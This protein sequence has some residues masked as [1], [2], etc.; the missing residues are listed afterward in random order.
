M[1][2]APPPTASPTHL[3]R[4]APADESPRTG[5]TFLAAGAML[6][7]MAAWFRYGFD[8]PP[9]AAA[10]LVALAA[11]ASFG[12]GALR[13][14]GQGSTTS[15]AAFAAGGAV[16]L[17]GIAGWLGATFGLEALGEAGG[18][19]IFAV[20]A[21][22]AALG[23]S[24]GS[25]RERLPSSVITRIAL[26]ALGFLVLAAAIYLR[27][28]RK[29]GNDY[30]P[31]QA[32]LFLLGFVL[33]FGAVWLYATTNRTPEFV[34]TFFL[35]LG[36]ALGS[37]LTLYALSRAIVDWSLPSTEPWQTWIV[38]Y[39]LVA[40]L[41]LIY[42]SLTLV[43]NRVEKS[44]VAR[45]SIGGF[46][47]LLYGILALAIFVVFNV[48]VF[49][50]V[51]YTLEW[52]KTRGLT[53]LTPATENLLAGLDKKVEAYVLM[54]PLHGLHL[55][56]K[57]ML[58]N[59]AA[60]APSKFQVFYINPDSANPAER[61]K[62][63]QLANRFKEIVSSG[64]RDDQEMSRGVLLVYGELPKDPNV[65]VPH[66]VIPVRRLFENQMKTFIFKGESEVMKEVDFLARKREK[67]RI[68]LLQG[69]NELDMNDKEG[70]DL[71]SPTLNLSR[72]GAG[73]LVA[74]L[75]KDNYDVRGLS[76][77]PADPEAKDTNI[78]HVAETG[79]GKKAEVPDDCQTLVILSPSAKLSA[80]ALD[81]IERY[82]DR[83]GSLFVGIG[84][85]GEPNF[86]KLKETGLE[87]LL[88]KYGVDVTD[89]FVLHIPTEE[90]RSA[91]RCF[92][93]VPDKGQT[94]LAQQF[95]GKVFRMVTPRIIKAGDVGEVQGRAA[96]G[97]RSEL[98]DLGGGL[99]RLFPD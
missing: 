16:V 53:T 65:P 64:G 72:L 38:G 15:S 3:P 52:S 74:N 54:S 11:L 6:T 83:G 28:V 63:D 18:L 50:T 92:A 96:A 73:K 17:L 75:T 45:Q 5:P 32:A 33:L 14:V 93:E 91:F 37:L 71:T 13:V 23:W 7:I 55:Q 59:A 39:A 81:A 36:S 61:E 29:I 90:F 77:R 40:G 44:A 69:D 2:D 87:G 94:V 51:T 80:D 66:A 97:R 62:F 60:F 12:W 26:F 30:W 89:R 19:A 84:I 41:G 4:P 98:R 34:T 48:F 27:A 79:A 78:V 25:L 42:S 9:V 21:L 99:A 47:T 82:M 10:W 58:D 86:S 20:L 57:T 22:G 76:F 49:R 95:S 31:E 35:V 8:T 56:M 67:Q 70:I 85:P 68:Y 88:K 43:G 1:S 46:A 24:G